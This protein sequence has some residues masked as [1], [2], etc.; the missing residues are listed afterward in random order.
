MWW[1]KSEARKSKSRLA[2]KKCSKWI[3][4]PA[5]PKA[6][7]SFCELLENRVLLSRPD[8]LVDAGDFYWDFYGGAY[9]VPLLRATDQ[10]VLGF[11]PASMRRIQRLAT[12]F[13]AKGGPLSDYKIGGTINSS[14]VR[15]E[16]NDANAPASIK[17]LN[18]RAAGLKMLKYLSPTFFNQTDP[19]R[20]IVTDELD[21]NLVDTVS[22]ATVFKKGFSGYRAGVGAVNAYVATLKHGGGLDA[23]KVLSE[24]HS[25]P[26]VEY[27]V[28]N[29]YSELIPS[30]VGA[31]SLLG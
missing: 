1:N 23:L 26:L 19:E 29:I 13:T 10:I 24:L 12:A 4:P 2:K 30:A 6:S 31:E 27:A 14:T 21:V 15:L 28:P 16:A 11:Y 22:P 20:I 7:H 9:Q 8:H 17:R 5:L 3:S 25:S 18:R